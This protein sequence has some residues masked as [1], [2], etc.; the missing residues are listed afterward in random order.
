M[1]AAFDIY[2]LKA[3]PLKKLLFVSDAEN[4]LSILKNTIKI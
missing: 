2:Y 1:F 3:K 4:R